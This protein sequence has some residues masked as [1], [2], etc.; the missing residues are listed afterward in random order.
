[1]TVYLCQQIGSS[2]RLYGRHSTSDVIG[3]DKR[4]PSFTGPIG[5]YRLGLAANKI[6][7][8]EAPKAPL[9]LS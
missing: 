7:A 9:T 4:N 3:L 2:G 5:F 6:S 1:M 8:G